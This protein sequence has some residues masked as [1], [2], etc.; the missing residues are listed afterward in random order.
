MWLIG[1]SL[2]LIPVYCIVAWLWTGWKAGSIHAPTLKSAFPAE[3]YD[4]NVH[5][6]PCQPRRLHLAQA[7]NVDRN[8]K[9]NMTLS[10]S[11]DSAC[12]HS[13]VPVV[14]YGQ[15]FLSQREV[16]ATDP[17]LQFQ[18]TSEHSN[19]VFVSDLIYHIVLTDLE[20]G[21]R[22]YWYQ[23]LVLQTGTVSLMASSR[24]ALRPV[25]DAILGETATYR[26]K[27]PPLAG[28]PT[29]IALVGDLGQTVN[30]SR[31]MAQIWRA[32]LAL[33]QPISNLII[34]GDM[35]YADSDPQRWV[36]WFDLMEPLLRIMPISVAAGNHEIECDNTTR[37]IFQQYENYF[38]NP[39]RVASAST[40]PVSE[41]YLDTLWHRS[42]STPSSFLG[43]YVYGNSFYSYQHGLSH[44]IVLNSY[45]FSTEGSPQYTWL[46]RELQQVNRQQTPWLIVVFHSPLY[47]TFL[48][49]IDEP[50]ALQ[51]KKAMEPLFIRY[52][53][54]IIVSGHDHAYM[55]TRSLKFGQVDP[56]GKSPIYLTLGAGGNR[57]GH[58]PGFRDEASAEDWVAVR[59]LD[60]FGYGHLLMENATHAH[61]TWVRDGIS[62][63]DAFQD[64]IWLENKRHA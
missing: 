45:T 17:P 35:S 9:L 59:T 30:S 51:M 56:M 36:S 25:V 16:R 22:L 10:F 11:L 6:Y 52:G 28:Q 54:N 61:F 29:A 41:Q 3:E 63:D 1:Y 53:V 48:G 34:A 33:H 43:Y 4:N 5:Q 15:S 64:Q 57:E 26:F 40:R 2:L 19:G 8:H 60:D 21:S 46:A 39:N 7:T 37:D 18:Y 55:R 49:H 31:T 12:S 38:R 27:T 20:A 13:I 32:R 62:M 14:R 42:C 23:I 24:R 44:I 50:Q 47:T 58:A